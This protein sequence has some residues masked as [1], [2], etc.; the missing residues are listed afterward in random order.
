MLKDMKLM[1]TV[2]IG[3]TFVYSDKGQWLF[4]LESIDISGHKQNIEVI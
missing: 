3:V 2:E 1:V 4:S